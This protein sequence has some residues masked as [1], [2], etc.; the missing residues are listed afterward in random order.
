VTVGDFLV[1]IDGFVGF[2]LGLLVGWLRWRHRPADRHY[3]LDITVDDR[4]SRG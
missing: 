1:A 2:G 3:S 4:R